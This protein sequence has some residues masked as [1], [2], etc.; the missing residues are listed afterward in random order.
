MYNLEHTSAAVILVRF[1][2]LKQKFLTYFPWRTI[3]EVNFT[4]KDGPVL[5][6]SQIEDQEPLQEIIINTN[7]K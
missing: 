7:L 1:Q 4:D 5:K 6:D 2:I 3:F